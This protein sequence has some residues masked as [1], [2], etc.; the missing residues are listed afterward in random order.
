VPDRPLR[1]AAAV[2][3]ASLALLLINLATVHWP[4][5]ASL[6]GPTHGCAYLLVIAL[7]F[8]RTPS[9]RVRA[10][11]WIPGVGGVL[12]LRQFAAGRSSVR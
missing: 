5:A 1:V 11:A 9:A 8:R 10:T 6:L 2:E 4:A 12:V 3:L 7:T